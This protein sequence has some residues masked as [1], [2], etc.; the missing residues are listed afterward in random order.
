MTVMMLLYIQLCRC[1]RSCLH[2]IN[3]HRRHFSV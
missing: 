1:I 3:H 2:Y